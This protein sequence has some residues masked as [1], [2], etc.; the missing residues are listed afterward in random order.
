MLKSQGALIERQTELQ[1]LE[2]QIVA[3]LKNLR[4]LDAEEKQLLRNAIAAAG[5]QVAALEAE[6][7]VLKRQR[8]TFWKKAKYFI[9]GG[10]AGAAV[11]AVACRR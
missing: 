3:G 11:C 10:I 5:R 7:V 9:Y 2:N 8:M 6:V 1:D 4:T